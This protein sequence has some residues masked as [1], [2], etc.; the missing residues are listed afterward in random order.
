VLKPVSAGQEARLRALQDAMAGAASV[1]A[2]A[3]P[4]EDPATPPAR[5]NAVAVRLDALHTAVTTVRAVLEDLY[6]DLSDVQKA[7]FNR[8]GQPGPA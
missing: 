4:A 6:S 7:R 8:I 2:A 3:C 5:L 1:L